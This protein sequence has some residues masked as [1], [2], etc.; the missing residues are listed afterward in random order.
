MSP[1]PTAEGLR[2]LD[3]RY[4]LFA[5]RLE[6]PSAFE[7]GAFHF[8]AKDNLC[9]EDSRPGPAV[10]YCRGIGRRSSGTPGGCGRRGACSWARRTWTSS[11]SA[12][13]APT[14]IRHPPEPF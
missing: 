11:V 5:D 6:D 13:S 12:P 3:E 8:S 10:G 7:E 2:A 1:F 14:R 9:A 4:R